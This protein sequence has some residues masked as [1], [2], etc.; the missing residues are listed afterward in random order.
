MSAQTIYIKLRQAGMSAVGACAMLGNMQA[1]SGLKA[2]I[3]E[4]RCPISDEDYTAQVDA[5][6]YTDFATDKGKHYGYGLCQWTY[7]QRKVELLSFARS[8]GA[9]IGDEAMQVDFCVHELRRDYP[10]L[11]AY[12]CTCTGVS[13]AAARICKEY[14]RPAELT[15]NIKRRSEYAN[16]F[17]MTLSGMDIN[18]PTGEPEDE[19]FHTPAGEPSQSPSVTAP[20]EGEPSFWPPRTLE[21]GMSGPDVVALQGLL[22]AH[23]FA[24]SC[25][26]QFGNKTRTALLGFQAEKSGYGNGVADEATWAALTR[27]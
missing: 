22:T 12:L 14:E 19:I 25:D 7:P 16:S 17:Y 23:G 5:G 27:R 4:K 6:I 10:A 13:N 21:Y 18:A 26:G 15:E 11:W 3:V 2:N 9:T 20:P 24:T 8:R 1:E